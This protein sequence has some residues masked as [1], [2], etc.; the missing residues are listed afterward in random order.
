[1]GV[2]HAKVA[3]ASSTG[4]AASSAHGSQ[5]PAAYQGAN[6][7]HHNNSPNVAKGQNGEAYL[8]PALRNQNQHGIPGKSVLYVS[9]GLSGSKKALFGYF[10]I[11][12]QTFSIYRLLVL[13]GVNS[14]FGAY[15]GSSNG[16]GCD[17][18]R[19]QQQQPQPFHQQQQPF[20]QQPNQTYATNPD[21]ENQGRWGP[22]R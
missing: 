22:P 6:R 8:P 11:I 15:G 9:V 20:H 17:F 10:L 14:E 2:P 13:L 12:S 16:Y 1:M 19:Q 3:Q 7:H 18:T 21:E 5:A 4:L